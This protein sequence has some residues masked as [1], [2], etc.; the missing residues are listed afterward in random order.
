MQQM[1]QSL[2]IV[3]VEER[4]ALPMFKLEATKFELVKLVISAGIGASM[5]V[6]IL[7]QVWLFEVVSSVGPHNRARIS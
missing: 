5:E 6:F 7:Q 2:I 4:E 3:V 1:S